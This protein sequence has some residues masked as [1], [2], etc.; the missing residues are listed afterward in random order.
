MLSENAL[1]V[2]TTHVTVKLY[3]FGNSINTFDDKINDLNPMDA[4]NGHQ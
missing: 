4:Q 1:I 3:S 2:A